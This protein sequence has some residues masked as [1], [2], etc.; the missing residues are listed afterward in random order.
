VT[1]STPHARNRPETG[2]DILL[3]VTSRTRTRVR[4]SAVLTTA[5]GLLLLV[6]GPAS[7]EVPEG[8]SNPPD[9]SMLEALLILAGIPLLLIVVISAAVY[10]PAMVRGERAREVE[11]GGAGGRW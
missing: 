7:A 3:S 10:V 8:W 1:D 11:T 9:V 6:A 5:A 4:R 2:A